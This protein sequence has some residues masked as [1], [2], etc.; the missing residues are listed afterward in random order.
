MNKNDLNF[1]ILPKI[2]RFSLKTSTKMYVFLYMMWARCCFKLNPQLLVRWKLLFLLRCT[3]PI[4][5]HQPGLSGV[6]KTFPPQHNNPHWVSYHALANSTEFVT[7]HF[8]WRAF[9]TQPDASSSRASTM[10]FIAISPIT[11]T[12]PDTESQ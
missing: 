9:T 5:L 3:D 10:N 6:Q 12:L 7:W 4:L 11:S 1:K 2:K 8:S